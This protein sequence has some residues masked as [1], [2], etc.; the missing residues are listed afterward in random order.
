MSANTTVMPTASEEP[1][2]VV[3]GADAG[4]QWFGEHNMFT[5]K[6]SHEAGLNPTLSYINASDAVTDVSYSLLV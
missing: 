5:Y 2:D 6:Y 4:N 1:W 3:A